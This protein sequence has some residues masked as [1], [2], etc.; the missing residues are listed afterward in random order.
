M[1]YQLSY[2]PLQTGTTQ[3]QRQT[4][5]AELKSNVEPVHATSAASDPRTY[6]AVTGFVLPGRSGAASGPDSD[7]TQHHYGN[8]PE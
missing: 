8:E 2:D 4:R 3:H 1:L 6:S 7:R 5:V